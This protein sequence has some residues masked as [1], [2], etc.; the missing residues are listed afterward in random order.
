MSRCQISRATE[1]RKLAS[2][3]RFAPRLC[4]G[5]ASAPEGNNDH[6]ELVL[7]FVDAVTQADG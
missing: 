4:D 5:G 3:A 7:A 2:L 6:E 1:K